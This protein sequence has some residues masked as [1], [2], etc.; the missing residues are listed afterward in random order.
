MDP[1]ETSHRSTITKEFRLVLSGHYLFNFTLPS[2]V[3]F[4]Q[5]FRKI[6]TRHRLRPD[7]FLPRPSMS[8]VKQDVQ[9]SDHENNNNN[10]KSESLLRNKL[11]NNPILTKTE[12]FVST[13]QT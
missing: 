8:V 7:N 3:G 5:Y 6:P 2:L 10:N 12:I 9:F 1:L 11:W 4:K 13:S